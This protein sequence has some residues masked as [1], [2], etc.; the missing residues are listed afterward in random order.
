MILK[1][2]IDSRGNE[3][4]QIVIT[5]QIL[6]TTMISKTAVIYSNDSQES[7][8]IIELFKTLSGEFKIYRLDEHF[9]QRAFEKEFGK[10]ANLST[11]CYWIKTYWKFERDIAVYEPERDAVCQLTNWFKVPEN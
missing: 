7:L 10:E 3:T 8:R 2:V 9:T 6:L 4:K 5:I 1:T 11:S